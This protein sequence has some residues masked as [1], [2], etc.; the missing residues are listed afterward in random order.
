MSHFSDVKID[1]Q[2]CELSG[3]NIID[4]GG[5]GIVHKGVWNKGKKDE[6][7]I[8]AKIV[9]REDTPESTRD[10]GREKNDGHISVI[11][12]VQA[13]VDPKLLVKKKSNSNNT[14]T[15]TKGVESNSD[16]THTKNSDIYSFGVLMWEIYTCRSPFDGRGGNDLTLA[17]CFGE[18]EKPENGMPLDYIS[19]YEKCWHLIPSLRPGIPKILNDLRTLKPNPTYQEDN[20]VPSTVTE[21]QCSSKRSSTQS[22]DESFNQIIIEDWDNSRTSCQKTTLEEPVN[23]DALLQCIKEAQ[24]LFEE[25]K[26]SYKNAQLNIRICG[27]LNR[28]INS[29]EYNL[30]NL[31]EE[32]KRP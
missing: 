24:K 12:G 29:A 19:I 25:I 32:K 3:L 14:H 26:M 6:R 2:Y 4:R 15:D 9:I 21:S 11:R 31:E 13:Y 27:V 7:V 18:R 10:F 20:D 17:I 8:A 22:Y 30:K 16:Y 23:F 28:C 5:F 1:I